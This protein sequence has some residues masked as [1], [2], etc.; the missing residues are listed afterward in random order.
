[1]FVNGQLL[2][3]LQH[4]QLVLAKIAALPPVQRHC[5]AALG[6]RFLLA[7]IDHRRGPQ[8]GRSIPAAL[9]LQPPRR[10]NAPGQCRQHRKGHECR[11]AADGTGRLH[12]KSPDRPGKRSNGERHKRLGHSDSG[13]GNRGGAGWNPAGWFFAVALGRERLRGSRK[14]S[15]MLERRIGRKLVV[16]R[17]GTAAERPL[18]GMGIGAENT[19]EFRARGAFTACRGA[20]P[21]LFPWPPPGRHASQRPAFHPAGGQK[22]VIPSG[23]AIEVIAWRQ[24]VAFIL[25]GLGLELALI[26]NKPIEPFGD[27]PEHALL[28]RRDRRHLR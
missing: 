14:V 25:S 28:F 15:P 4:P 6:R 5:D 3:V 1:M 27:L 26:L 12:N 18:E 2:V 9:E 16:T 13:C 19:E 7:G 24:P 21:S 8:H 17:A 11:V 10:A 23:A 22:N 20:D